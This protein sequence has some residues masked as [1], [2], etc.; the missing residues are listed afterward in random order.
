MN[1]KEKIKTRIVKY[2][3]ILRFERRQNNRKVRE[4]VFIIIEA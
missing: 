4:Y 3:I 2:N 1:H